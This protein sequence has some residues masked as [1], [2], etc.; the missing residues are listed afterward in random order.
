MSIVPL[1]L[2]YRTESAKKQILFFE[3]L[4]TCVLYLY[5]SVHSFVM[6]ILRQTCSYV[7]TPF[8]LPLCLNILYDGPP[9]SP[10]LPK[11]T[12]QT[13]TDIAITKMLC[14]HCWSSLLHVVLLCNAHCPLIF[15][16]AHLFFLSCHEL[17]RNF[18]QVA[19]A[20]KT[21][22]LKKSTCFA[23]GGGGGAATLSLVLLLPE[24]FFFLKSRF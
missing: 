7:H 1:D 18:K 14:A 5:T 19:K 13:T 6:I 17:Y 10:C 20:T 16:S 2:I 11:K 9:P 4:H 23:M 15:H 22:R 24:A 21:Q 8:P 3:L 12:K